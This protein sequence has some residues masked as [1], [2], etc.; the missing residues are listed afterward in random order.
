MTNN[1]GEF[2]S[3]GQPSGGEPVPPTPAGTEGGA[4]TPP[5][6]PGAPTTPDAAPAVPAAVP[7]PGA[8][9]PADVPP[10]APAAPAEPLAPATPAQTEPVPPAPTA[11]TGTDQPGGYG[12]Q[13][14]QPTQPYGAAAPGY[15]A[16]PTDTSGQAG[17]APG[18]GSAPTPGYPGTAA[19]GYA[20]TAQA[21][22]QYPQPGYQQSQPP[23]KKKGLGVGAIIG[24]IVGAV[25]LLGV[26]VV[27]LIVFLI[28]RGPEFNAAETTENYLTAL[29]DGDAE[30]ALAMSEGGPSD[31]TLLTD[32]VLAQAQEIAPITD[33]D[34][35]D[36]EDD[37]GTGIAT[38]SASYMV[39]DQQV[40][41]DFFLNLDE[42]A[43]E[44]KISE[45]IVNDIFLSE[46]LLDIGV[47]VNGVA[48]ESDSV[49][50]FPGGYLVETP[51]TTY[52]LVGETT[53]V[54]AQPFESGSASDI[55]IEL[56]E[57]GLAGWRQ[58]VTDAVNACLAEKTLEA[59]CGLS[60]PALF[61]DGTAFTDGTLTRTLS[62][63][64]QA[65]LAALEPYY[66]L[67]DPLQVSAGYIGLVDVTGDC[68]KNGQ[69]GT[70]EITFGQ[71]SLSSPLVDYA[72]DPPT[73]RWDG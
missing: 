46:G 4:P 55:E 22:Q 37:N 65:E 40:N 41:Q 30:A 72:T 20:D 44:W 32:E 11:P 13:H 70:C 36:G 60:I 5:P 7:D 21:T 69:S 31:T 38:I 64:G 49:P 54:L 9:V 59:G 12:A 66:P 71:P 25:V 43:N 18:Y 62:A 42:E 45:A 67:F 53:L 27:L 3:T 35:E 1:G 50:A 16:P 23:Q 24:I 26:I 8:Q 17:A 2:D 56:S 19:P 34:V 15:G 10:A 29:A 28:P 68:T 52:A 33:I 57:D 39:G 63:E 47:T 14:T 48:V 73:L 51:N 6:P 61:G 58:L